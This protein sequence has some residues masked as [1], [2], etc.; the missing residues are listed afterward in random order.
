MRDWRTITGIALGVALAAVILAVVGGPRLFGGPDFP[1]GRMVSDCDGPIRTLVIQ[2]VAAAGETVEPTYRDF[3]PALPRG[4]TV[5]VVCP[6]QSDFDDLTAR[7]GDV[8]CTLKPVLTGHSHTPWSRDRWVALTTEDDSPRTW[9][10]HQRG[11]QMR[12]DWPDRRADERIPPFLA[13]FLGPAVRSHHSSHYF[14]GGDFVCDR[15]MIFMTPRVVER[16]HQRTVQSPDALIAILDEMTT[17]PLVAL[18]AAPD[19][20]AGM[21]MMPIG[22]RRMLVGD[23]ALARAIVGDRTDLAGKAG[24][25]WSEKAQAAFDAVAARAAEAGY[26]VARIPVVPGK[27]GRT[28]L[29]YLNVIINEPTPGKRVVYMPTFGHVPQLNAAAARVWRAAGYAVVPV[30]CTDCYVHGG[31]LRCLVSVLDRG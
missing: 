12:D 7:V 14:D 19:H 24:E 6:Q 21:Y 15:D 25:D 16:N 1:R 3:L 9:I 17:Q 30:D 2:Y 18:T 26:T 13:S 23:P 10:L 28:Y 4:V 29:T 27:D 5:L 22:D 31:S 20:H 11:E 8:A